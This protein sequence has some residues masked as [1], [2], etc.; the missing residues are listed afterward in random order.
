MTTPPIPDH[1]VER[2]QHWAR[3]LLEAPADGTA[4]QAALEPFLAAVA[5]MAADGAFSAYGQTVERQ[6][7][8]VGKVRVVLAIPAGPRT[9][10]GDAQV[11]RAAADGDKKVRDLLDVMKRRANMPQWKKNLEAL[12]VL[13]GILGAMALLAGCVIAVVAGLGG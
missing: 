8:L 5:A 9:V 4:H 13:G 6:D 3:I 12:A 1:V 2:A 7:T 11:L 10:D